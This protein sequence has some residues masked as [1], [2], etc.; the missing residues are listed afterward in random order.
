MYMDSVRGFKDKWYV[1][2][3]VTTSALKSLYEEEAPKSDDDGE[4]VLDNNGYPVMA[5][6]AKF[7]VH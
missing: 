1:V 2:R 4:A 3:P 7:H 5:R 6:T